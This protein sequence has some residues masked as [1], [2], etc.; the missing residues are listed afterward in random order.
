MNKMY[1]IFISFKNLDEDGLPTRDSIIAQ[2][3]YEF[4]SSKN[5]N[6]FFSKVSLEYLGVTDYKKM[7]DDALD[8]AN[9][10]IAVG[11]SHK[12]LNSKW[13]RYEWDGFLTDILSDVKKQGQI[14][15]YGENIGILDL[16]RGL[17]QTQFFS[18]TQKSMLSLYNFINQSLT[19]IK[20]EIGNP[21][22]DFKNQY[23]DENN[24][25][26]IKKLK[27]EQKTKLERLSFGLSLDNEQNEF[28]LVDKYH[29]YEKVRR[30]D[31]LDTKNGMYTSHRWLTLRNISNK[32]TFSI[33]HKEAGDC[34]IKF[35]NLNL[36][37]YENNIN[38]NKLYT[39]SLT[40]LQPSFVQVIEI[41]FPYPLKKNELIEIYYNISWPGEPTVYSGDEHSQSISLT[42]YMHG[43]L[44]LEF[45]L[46]ETS[47][48]SSIR[49]TKLLNTYDE[50]F[51]DVKPIFMSTEDC[52]LFNNLYG[53]SYKGHHYIF[54]IPEALSYRIFYHLS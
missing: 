27:L 12:N 30:I 43:V 4:L 21:Q 18:H 16:P 33:Y 48:I 6:V 1:D 10:V 38:G 22:I 9:I 32:Q 39:K 29:I 53:N 49:C 23:T 46:L 35:E 7:I 44:H 5:L 20:N 50:E 52:E 40:Q 3:L 19:S 42:R 25:V 13:V 15:C 8:S 24:N 45:G 37:A 31:I 14:F 41:F 47:C 26:E 54:E 17:R 51:V 2:E 36:E 28:D 34:K 11:T